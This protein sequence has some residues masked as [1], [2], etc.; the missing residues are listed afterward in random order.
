MY[1][2]HIQNDSTQAQSVAEHSNNIGE[3]A[4]QLCSLKE[5]KMT[6]FL[7]GLL[8]DAGKNTDEFNEYILRAKAD[9]SS[10]SRGEVIHSASGGCLITELAEK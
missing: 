2:A 6:A 3:L 8:H 10:V 7:T 9:P 5:L 1:I 4:K